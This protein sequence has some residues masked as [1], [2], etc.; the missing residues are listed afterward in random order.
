VDTKRELAELRG[1]LQSALARLDAL[2]AALHGWQATTPDAPVDPD[3]DEC[4][5][6]TALRLQPRSTFVQ[7]VATFLRER[8]FITDKQRAA[9]QKSNADGES[10]AGESTR[11]RALTDELRAGRSALRENMAMNRLHP[12]GLDRLGLGPLD[13]AQMADEQDGDWP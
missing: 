4:I 13:I 5:V 3:T 11:L 10:R 12:A 1:V 6:A 7:N 2:D 8:G 9:L